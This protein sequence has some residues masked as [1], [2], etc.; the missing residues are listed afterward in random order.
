VPGNSQS[1]AKQLIRV[2]IHQ[3]SNSGIAL[4]LFDSKIENPMVFWQTIS[5]SL[6]DF[7]ELNPVA[8]I[9]FLLDDLNENWSLKLARILHNLSAYI[10]HIPLDLYLSNW[11]MVVGQLEVFFRKYYTQ[12]KFI[13][14]NLIKWI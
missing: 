6:V 1:V 11:G 4:Q 14:K 7:S 5:N 12:V 10:Q 2:I 3:L 8:L 9:Q 13:L